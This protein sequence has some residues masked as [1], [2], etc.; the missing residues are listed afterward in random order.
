MDFGMQEDWTPPKLVA[1]LDREIEHS[2]IP[3]GESAAFINRVLNGLMA[4]YSIESVNT[5]ALDRFRLRDQI[6]QRMQQHRDDER[7]KAFQALLLPDSP[8]TVDDNV[9]FDFLKEPYAPSW[10]C[11]SAYVF[12]KHYFGAKPGELAEKT[13][14]GELAEEFLCAQ[15]IDNLDEVEFW[16]R[17]LA[18]KPGSVRLQTSTDWFYPDFVCKLKDG[19]VAAVEYKGG[20]RISNEDS[21]N[22]LAVGTVWQSRSNGRCV[23]LM[24]TNRN[25]SAIKEALISTR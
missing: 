8:L 22:K 19:R 11:E 18:G 21:Q 2:D 23:F 20:D 4:Q 12:K 15:Y 6:R 17:N 10:Y 13:S 7:K 9:V 14:T 1:W 24:P 3:F 5:L 16:A 25:F